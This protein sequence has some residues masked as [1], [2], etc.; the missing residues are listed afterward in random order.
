MF[1]KGSISVCTRILQT[2]VCIS[3]KDLFQSVSSVVRYSCQQKPGL[4]GCSRRSHV[5]QKTLLFT[6]TDEWFQETT[7]ERHL[8]SVV[9]SVLFVLSK[10]NYPV[11]D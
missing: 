2:I 8:H 5:Y 4:I 6:K 10:P 11:V 7:D 1:V 9:V 3:V